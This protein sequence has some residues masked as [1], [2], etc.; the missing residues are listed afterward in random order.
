MKL[1]LIHIS[2]DL[3]GTLTN[4]DKVVTPKTREAMLQAEAEG[5]DVYKRQLLPWLLA[6]K[7]SLIRSLQDGSYLSLIHISKFLNIAKR[8][9]DCVVKEVGPKPGQATIVPGHQIAEMALAR[10]YTLTGEKTV[11]YTHLWLRRLTAPYP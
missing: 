2:L 7:D 6:N 1:S 4:H 3:D 5:V 9:A 8:Y 11:S 10:L